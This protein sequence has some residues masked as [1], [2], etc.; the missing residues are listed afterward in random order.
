MTMETFLY[1]RSK[2]P[3]PTMCP[4]SVRHAITHLRSAVESHNAGDDEHVGHDLDMAL[5][6]L[7]HVEAKE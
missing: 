2:I 4:A 1:A 6:I 5:T 3:L 7:A